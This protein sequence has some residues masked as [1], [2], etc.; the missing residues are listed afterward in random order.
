MGCSAT[1]CKNCKRPIK[2]CE[3]KLALDGSSCCKY[4]V[5]TKNSQITNK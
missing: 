1:K 2:A 4:C 3:K 5:T